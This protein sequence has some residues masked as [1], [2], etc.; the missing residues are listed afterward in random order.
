MTAQ[1]VVIVSGSVRESVFA[2]P[3]VAAL[4]GA[5]VFAPPE[6][7]GVLRLRTVGR[8]FAVSSDAGLARAWQRLRGLAAGMVVLP[9][10]VSARSA[11]L[12]Y[13]SGI[14]RR[15]TIARR[16]EWWA[17][18]RVPVAPTLHPVDQVRQLAAFILEQR[19]PVPE[20]QIELGSATQERVDTR[21]ESAGLRPHDRILLAIPGR[22]NW[23]RHPPRPLWPAERFAVLA[24]QLRPD[25]VVLV[26]GAGDG[27]AV[28]DM[29]AGLPGRTAVV[30]LPSVAADELAVLARRSLAVIGHDGD[31]LHVAA[32]AGGRTIALL[33]P[34]D[35]AP[36]GENGAALRVD[37][38]EA[39]PARQVLEVARQHLGVPAHV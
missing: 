7:L 13:F 35:L 16:G 28:R 38:L 29:L 24:N 11:I 21:L 8:G 39:V 30:D 10:P 3:L 5:W 36:Y 37:A 27:P 1:P 33:G 17:T 12:A 9:P 19:A 2:Q 34:S 22:G 14:S 25:L 4:D 18:D 31:A 15:V 23:I 26:R 6:G 32:A 20:P